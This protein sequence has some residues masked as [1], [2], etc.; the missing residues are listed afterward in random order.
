MGV[1]R[2]SQ[3]AWVH[4]MGVVM[5]I[6]FVDDDNASWQGSNLTVA[7]LTRRLLFIEFLTTIPLVD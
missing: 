4:D 2:K 5:V 1:V 6:E 3:Q 7:L